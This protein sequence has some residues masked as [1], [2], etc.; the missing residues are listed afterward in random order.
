LFSTASIENKKAKSS[1]AKLSVLKKEISPIK[2]LRYPE[3]VTKKVVSKLDAL[4][5]KINKR[6]DFHGSLLV[7]K[8]GKIIYNNQVGTSDFRKK[9]PLNEHS[10]FS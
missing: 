7:A 4:L 8:K 9:E 10:V 1:I 2:I 5:S 3:K 6:N